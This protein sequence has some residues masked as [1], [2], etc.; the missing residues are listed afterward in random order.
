MLQTATRWGGAERT[1]GA[2]AGSKLKRGSL[3]THAERLDGTAGARRRRA[4]APVGVPHA[5]LRCTHRRTALLSS[6]SS[7]VAFLLALTELATPVGDAVS[8]LS[9]TRVR[10]VR[11][12][13]VRTFC[14]PQPAV[15]MYTFSRARSMRWP[16]R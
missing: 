16:R 4:E 2:R 15:H 8:L 5:G 1:S 12:L 3:K 7:S 10:A 11:A 9:H 6:Y 13:C 14:E